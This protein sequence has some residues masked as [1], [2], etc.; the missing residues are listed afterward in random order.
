MRLVG[1]I[2]N[3]NRLNYIQMQLMNHLHPK[4]VLG[5]DFLDVADFNDRNAQMFNIGWAVHPP[6]L[7]NYFFVGFGTFLSGL[8]A[9]APEEYPF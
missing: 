6:R 8:W 1:A 3:T 7:A 2:V 4:H 9:N 5:D